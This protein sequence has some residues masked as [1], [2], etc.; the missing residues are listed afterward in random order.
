MQAINLVIFEAFHLQRMATSLSI[1]SSAFN[2]SSS[3]SCVVQAS[4]TFGWS[5]HMTIGTHIVLVQKCSAQC[6]SL[7]FGPILT[8]I[9]FAV[10]C[11]GY[12]CPLWHPPRKTGLIGCVSNFHL[13]VQY[14]LTGTRKDPK[15]WNLFI[16]KCVFILTC[17]NFSHLQNTLHL[18]QYTY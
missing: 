1:R 11:Y 14:R 10:A 5:L 6:F 15:T 13:Q 2:I 4:Q 17:L 7:S 18:M 8:S 16:K 3:I 9:H 12:M